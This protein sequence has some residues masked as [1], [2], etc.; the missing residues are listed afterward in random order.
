L[1]VERHTWNLV[2]YAY[3]HAAPGPRRYM[4]GGLSDT[5]FR[6]IPFIEAGGDADVVGP[7]SAA[8]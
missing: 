8:G 1:A 2:G 4:F 3:G 6:L 7:W 5:A